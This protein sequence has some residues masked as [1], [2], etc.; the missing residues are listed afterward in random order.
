MSWGE[1]WFGPFETH[2][3]FGPGYLEYDIHSGD[4]LRDYPMESSSADPGWS[5]NTTTISS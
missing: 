5:S 4:D 2:L 1:I 3:E